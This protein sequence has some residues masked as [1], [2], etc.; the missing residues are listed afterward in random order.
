[1]FIVCKNNSFEYTRKN[2]VYFH[3]MLIF[4]LH[5]VQPVQYGFHTT[6]QMCEVSDHILQ[7]HMVYNT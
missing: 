3:C 1:L 4:D 2:I 5:V 6:K 7:L